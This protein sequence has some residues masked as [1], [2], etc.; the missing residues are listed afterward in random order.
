METLPHFLNQIPLFGN[1]VVGMFLCRKLGDDSVRK[2]AKISET[3]TE[4][5]ASVSDVRPQGKKFG[6]TVRI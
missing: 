6:H 5:L 2:N 3:G 4:K 1:V